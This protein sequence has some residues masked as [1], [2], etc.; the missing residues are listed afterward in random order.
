MAAAARSFRRLSG[1]AMN[2]SEKHWYVIARDSALYI[3]RAPFA[4][5]SVARLEQSLQQ[6][7]AW[8]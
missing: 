2:A 4:A 5:V 8:R 6:L 3:D 1:K 7:S